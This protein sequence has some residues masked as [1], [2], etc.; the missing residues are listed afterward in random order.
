[1]IIYSLNVVNHRGLCT[2]MLLVKMAAILQFVDSMIRSCRCIAVVSAKLIQV[3]WIRRKNCKLVSL[4]W[5][6]TEALI[7][8]IADQSKQSFLHPRRVT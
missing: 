1:M 5:Q 4:R 8:N 6:E 7:V 3:P 2:F